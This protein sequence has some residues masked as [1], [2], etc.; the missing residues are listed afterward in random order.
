MSKDFS[1]AALFGLQLIG[2]ISF[3]A[4]I[5]MIVIAFVSWST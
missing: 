5:A 2:L 4:V 1:R 3:F